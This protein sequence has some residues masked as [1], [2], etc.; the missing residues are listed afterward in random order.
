MTFISG[1]LLDN[2]LRDCDETDFTTQFID[3]YFFHASSTCAEDSVIFLMFAH[4]FTDVAV[5]G[6]V[7]VYYAVIYSQHFAS[8]IILYAP[9][10]AASGGLIFGWLIGYVYIGRVNSAL[11]GLSLAAASYLL[12]I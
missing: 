11:M 12:F 2:L 3:Y 9:L 10:A 1:A 5:V 4:T 6:N 8:Y 7:V